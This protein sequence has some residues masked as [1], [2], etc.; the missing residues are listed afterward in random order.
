MRIGKKITGH[1]GASLSQLVRKQNPDTVVINYL[2]SAA[3]LVPELTSLPARIFI[4][5]HGYDT[6]VDQR[7]CDLQG[8]RLHPPDYHQRVVALADR[9][10]LLAN[11][12]STYKRLVSLGI[13]EASLGRF[14]F[15]IRIPKERPAHAAGPATILYL[16]RFVDM[17]GPDLTIRAF[18]R[19]CDLGLQGRL[20][21]GGDG[22]LG[23]MCALMRSRSRYRERIEFLGAVPWDQVEPTLLSADIFTA[24]NQTGECTGQQEAFGVAFA[25]AMAAGLPVVTG[26]SGSLPELV[27]HG[28]DGMLFNP[29]DIEAHARA[30]L[31]LEANPSLRAAM[32]QSARARMDAEFNELRVLRQLRQKLGLPSLPQ[33]LTTYVHNR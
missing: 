7:S 4:L 2:N 20:I 30:L 21:M 10:T 17:K 13:R 32:G 8:K 31:T 33:L 25:E 9:C 24:H 23:P 28:S 29:G 16:G 14:T 18:E 27:R 19:A 26:A 11:S 1:P 22:P 6:F 3:E 12:E 15:G 5:C